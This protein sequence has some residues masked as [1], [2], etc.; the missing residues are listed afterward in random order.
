V[1]RPERP[2]RHRALLVEDNA[3][4]R[5]LLATFLRGAGMEVATA[6]D[7]SDAL[8]YLR[9]QARPDVVLLDMGL[10]RCDGAAVVRAMRQDPAYAGVKIFAVTG[11]GPE[12]FGLG[13][14]P[15]GV[16][17][18]FQKPIDPTDLV[19]GVEQELDQAQC[20]L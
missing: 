14:G 7:G 18:W 16:D 11:H 1:P 12:E 8:D 4:E 15:A 9:Q 3:N 20:R 13:Q 6:G 19:R 2:A 5:Q 10:P 17:R